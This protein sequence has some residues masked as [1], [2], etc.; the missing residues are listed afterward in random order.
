MAGDLRKC[1]LTVSVVRSLFLC[2]AP[3]G[4]TCSWPKSKFRKIPK[5]RFSNKL[6]FQNKYFVFLKKIIRDPKKYNK[7]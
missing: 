2:C 1:G 3:S 7:E 4:P 6:V 5:K